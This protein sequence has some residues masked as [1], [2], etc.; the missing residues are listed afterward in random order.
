MTTQTFDHA[1]SDDTSVASPDPGPQ[2][3]SGEQPPET[4]AH[5]LYTMLIKAMVSIRINKHLHDFPRIHQSWKRPVDKIF[6][7]SEDFIKFHQSDI[8]THIGKFMVF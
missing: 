2:S 7:R 5:L 3:R 8:P 1:A 4:S 6:T